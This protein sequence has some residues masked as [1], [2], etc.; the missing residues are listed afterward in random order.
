MPITFDIQTLNAEAA[1]LN[2]EQTGVGAET[3]LD[4]LGIAPADVQNI[5]AAEVPSPPADEPVAD[6]GVRTQ[7][8]QS[9]EKRLE[10]MTAEEIYAMA[11][12]AVKP[13]WNRLIP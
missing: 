6:T 11:D 12:P 8:E 7:Q 13:E 4:S 5:P 3:T 2:A 1:A 10:D 9:V